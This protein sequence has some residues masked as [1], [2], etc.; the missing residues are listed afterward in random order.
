ML[1]AQVHLTLPAWIHEVVDPAATY[2][3]DEAKV[4]LAI[5]LSR[6]NVEA[7]SGGPFGAVV[8][9]PDHRVI[10]AGVNR[11]VPHATSLAHAENMAY[12]LAQQRLQ[13]PRLNEVLSPVTLATSSQ[14]CCQCYGAT[15]WAGI[16][17]LLIG[18]RAEDV[19]E[20]T[21]F[22]EGPL[23]AD[24]IGELE[25][26]GITVVRDLL[27]EQARQVLRAYGEGGGER[28]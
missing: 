12:M 28:Y 5:E 11:V 20:L 21:E 3:S 13:A 27:R 6:R 22:D 26:R 25:R 9:G 14:P 4:A 1:Y 16:D 7:R 10:A 2:E 17:R 24:W 15:I 23:P 18:A 8:F 19:M